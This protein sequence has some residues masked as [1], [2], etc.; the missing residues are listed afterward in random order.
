MAKIKK[1]FKK[2]SHILSKSKMKKVIGRFIAN[3]FSWIKKHKKRVLVVLFLISYTLFWY[4]FFSERNMAF[5]DNL[6]N[7]QIVEKNKVI[8]HEKDKEQGFANLGN[9]WL[10]INTDKV[11]VKAPVVNGTTDNE[12]DQGLGRHK[13]TALP[14][15]NGNM[16]ISGHRWKFGDNPAYKVFENLDKL[17][18]GDKIEV[19]YGTKV[20]E[21]EV[22][23]QGTVRPNKKGGKE[24][25]KKTDDK[26]LTLYTCT[27]K[28]TALNR[29][30]Y[31]AKLVS[32]KT[33][34]KKNT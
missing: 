18:N 22:Y 4:W 33:E 29:L 7:N 32:V 8:E 30:Y 17:K 24:I 1:T 2:Y 25:L 26:I 5:D 23:E 11:K 13:T 6:E 15:E 21:Y 10:E 20:F 14:N 27:P 28:Y 12:L 9:F 16:V 34:E 31:R 19:H 3:S